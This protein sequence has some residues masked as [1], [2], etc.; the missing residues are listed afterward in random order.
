MTEVVEFVL[1]IIL[2]G[3]SEYKNPCSLSPQSYFVKESHKNFS[4]DYKEICLFYGY[5]ED[6]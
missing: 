6:I 4:L 5:F 3:C 2:S 1:L